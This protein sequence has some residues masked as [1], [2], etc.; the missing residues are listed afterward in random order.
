M[1]R[2]GSDCCETFFSKLG[3]FGAIQLNRRNFNCNDALETAC[4]LV[5]MALYEFDPDCPIEIKKA[6]ESLELIMADLEDD[7]DAD[8]ADLTAY[9]SAEQCV[10]AG[11][12]GLARA[13]ELAAKLGMDNRK[14]RPKFWSEPWA[15]EERITR[16]MRD[17]D[18][19][20]SVVERVVDIDAVSGARRTVTVPEREVGEVADAERDFVAEPSATEAEDE[21]NVD[22]LDAPQPGDDSTPPPRGEARP[23]SRRSPRFASMTD[24]GNHEDAVRARAELGEF[25]H[26]ACAEVERGI[27]EDETTAAATVAPRSGVSCHVTS[28]DG[29]ELHKA[30]FVT[31]LIVASATGEL[32]LSPDRLVRMAQDSSNRGGADVDNG[33]EEQAARAFLGRGV[34]IAQAFAKSSRP[35]DGFYFLLGRVQAV[36]SN[37]SGSYKEWKVPLAFESKPPGLKVVCRW[38]SRV[39]ANSDVTW[40]YDTDDL[41]RYFAQFTLSLPDLAYNASKK[42]YTLSAADRT[43]IPTA[44]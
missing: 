44:N 38:Y 42:E 34:D 15:N 6:N 10:A 17:A 20:D 12:R 36:Y 4:D 27:V 13:H 43:A 35:C 14:Q 28:P 18:S 24:D 23:S 26:E 41:S 9:P 7:R 11:D 22:E 39:R 32:I 16:A 29:R 25:V 33:D 40:K 37:S 1:A 3:G 8:D 21:A 19:E 2:S 5:K 31:E 30:T